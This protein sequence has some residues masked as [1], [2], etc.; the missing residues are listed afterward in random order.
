MQVRKKFPKI[1]LVYS[2][3]TP[4]VSK[5][6]YDKAFINRV[7]VARESAGLSPREVASHLGLKTNTYSKYETRIMMPHYLI[8]AFACLT[9]VTLAYLFGAK[10]APS[11]Q[12]LRSA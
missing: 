7:R 3:D 2:R 8:P 10:Q 1:Y 4:I 12:E 9:N 6:S 11:D 5:K